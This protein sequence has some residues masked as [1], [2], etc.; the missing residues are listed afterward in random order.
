MRDRRDANRA[1]QGLQHGRR[2]SANLTRCE[3]CVLQDADS[4]LAC[5]K[6]S[7]MADVGVIWRSR[8][9]RRQLSQVVL[10]AAP[11]SALTDSASKMP[12]AASE[13]AA[14]RFDDAVRAKDEAA[15]ARC[16]Q[17]RRHARAGLLALRC[18][19]TGW[20]EGLRTA[21]RRRR[22]LSVQD[23]VGRVAGA[24][25]CDGRPRHIARDPRPRQ[26]R[27]VNAVN[28]QK[29]TPLHFAAV[30]GNALA[31]SA[32]VRCG[33]DVNSAYIGW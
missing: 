8:D 32:L 17:M 15:P 25:R 2:A 27:P 5:T 14:Q 28:A 10:H 4:R 7:R 24:S 30:G 33:S 29:Q 11:D 18:A 22:D 12:S 3:E 16:G 9:T 23:R 19:E 6:T 31:V 13:A 20:I 1:A 26:I 21:G